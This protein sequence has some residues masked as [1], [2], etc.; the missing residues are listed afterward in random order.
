MNLGLPSW[1]ALTQ[2]MIR[3]FGLDEALLHRPHITYQTVAEY[4]LIQGGDIRLLRD[5][6]EA[7]GEVGPEALYRSKIHELIVSLDFPLIYTTNYDRNLELAYEHHKRSYV[8]ITTPGDVVR[9]KA[10]QTQI[11]KFHGDFDEPASLVLSETHHFERLFFNCP[12]DI[13]LRADALG[14]T[15]L[16]I[17]YSM[18]DMN[19]RLLLY[20]LWRTWVEAGQETDRPPSFVFT[21]D[22]DP[23]QEA[24]LGHWGIT[25][26]EGTTPDP[27]KALET[28]LGSLAKNLRG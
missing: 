19:I 13:K 21:S 25:V 12:L 16:F 24:V 7:D 11:I 23:I 4:F 26:I 18:S 5:W 27:G 6:L 2:R 17:G 14:R 20:R 8:K 9:A 15:I 28:F 22:P 10:G 3:H 1:H